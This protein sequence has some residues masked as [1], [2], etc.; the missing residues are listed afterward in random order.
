[1]YVK[2]ERD[3][4]RTTGGDGVVKQA[5]GKPGFVKAQRYVPGLDQ[6][7][8]CIH[9]CLQVPGKHGKDSFG[10]NG[11]TGDW[12]LGLNRCTP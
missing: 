4:I 12:R 9:L 3:W 5:L 11:V 6:E 8:I 10:P 7:G 1:M 2:S